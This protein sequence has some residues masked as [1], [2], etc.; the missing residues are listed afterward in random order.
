MLETK[1]E[2]RAQADVSFYVASSR[3]DEVSH[4]VTVEGT[5]SVGDAA[6]SFSASE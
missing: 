6:W 3:L 5:G 4:I 1:F 2:G